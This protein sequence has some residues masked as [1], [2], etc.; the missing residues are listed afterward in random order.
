V[1]VTD[2]TAGQAGAAAGA[3]A[4]LPLGL[5]GLQPDALGLGIFG[6]LF[7]S[8]C[9][10]TF[11]TRRRAFAA[12]VLCGFLAGFLAPIVAPAIAAE[13]DWLHSTGDAL[14]LPVALVLGVVGPT[15]LPLALMLIRARGEKE[16]R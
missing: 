11:N 2:T 7:V 1:T 3:L 15:L 4:A 9:L 6:A 14:R 12:V 5:I 8:I 16:A 10:P 13:F